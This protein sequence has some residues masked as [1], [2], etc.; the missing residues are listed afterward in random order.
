MLITLPAAKCAV[1]KDEQ[2]F[3]KSE[4]AAERDRLSENGSQQPL[5]LMLTMPDGRQV[6]LLLKSC[7]RGQVRLKLPVES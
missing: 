5:L 4:K 1:I 7:Q 6:Q 3:L 2:E